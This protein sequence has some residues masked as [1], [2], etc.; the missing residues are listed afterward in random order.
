MAALIILGLVGWGCYAAIG[1]FSPGYE[2][3]RPQSEHPTPVV[4]ALLSGAFVVYLLALRSAVHLRSTP[5]LTPVILGFAIAY[6]ALLVFTPPI[7]EVDLYRYLWDGQVAAEG[8]SPYRYS[9]ATVRNASPSTRGSDL[10]RL[11]ELRESSSAI[12][13]ALSRVHFAELTTVYPPVSQAVFGGAAIT[14]PREADLVTLRLVLKLWLLAFDVGT[15]GLLARLLSLVRKPPGWLIGYAWCP[16]V[17][18]EF[19]NSGHLD[20]IAVFWMIAAVVAAVQ[21]LFPSRGQSRSR[22]A[23]WC[24]VSVVCLALG[25]GAKLF[26]I[27][28]APLVAAAIWRRLGLRFAVLNGI[29]FLVSTLLILSPWY[30]TR[31]K[32]KDQASLVA[33]SPELATAPDELPPPMIDEAASS[34]RSPTVPAAMALPPQPLSLNAEDPGAGLTAFL[35]RWKMNDFLFLLLETNLSPG[36]R[37]D[38]AG[39]WFVITPRAWRESLCIGVGRWTGQPAGL[40]AFA[41]AR[42]VSLV[43]F[44][45]LGLWWTIRAGH[46]RSGGRWCEQAFLTLAW[47]WLLSPTLNPWYWT[48]AVPLLPFARS[49]IWWLMSGSLFIYYLRFWLGTQWPAAGIAGTPYTGH[50]FFD[51]VIVWIEFAPWLGLLLWSAWQRRRAVQPANRIYGVS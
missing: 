20:T 39:P 37:A 36:P 38:V 26:P 28:L 47:F 7:L 51:Y 19:A 23:A 3:G 18:K 24:S 9:P 11:V 6:R 8:I 30:F 50:Q 13:V 1:A 5:R 34:D 16:L 4:V 41:L 12:A 45:S 17:L 2:Y 49:R 15:I 31:M 44:S 22:G 46:A 27:V 32:W 35:T 25:V 42:A 14:A 29:L 21:G 43:V 40:V 48:W 33:E 10:Q